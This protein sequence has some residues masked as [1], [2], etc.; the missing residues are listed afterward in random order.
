[1]SILFATIDIIFLVYHFIQF[2][3]WKLYISVNKSFYSF[4]VDFFSS[5]F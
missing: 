1:M 4:V 5:K 3:I 2:E